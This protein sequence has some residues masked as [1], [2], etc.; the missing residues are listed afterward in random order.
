MP[1]QRLTYSVFQFPDHSVPVAVDVGPVFAVLDWCHV[2]L[3]IGSLHILI[4]FY[5]AQQVRYVAL[6]LVR[7]SRQGNVPSKRLRLSKLTSYGDHLYAL[8]YKPNTLKQA[9]RCLFTI[10]GPR[11]LKLFGSPQ[12]RVGRWF[13]PSIDWVGLG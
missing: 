7:Q 4:V 5:F 6:Q 9:Y 11:S 2:E 10:S 12:L 3:Y 13:G 8:L 1:H